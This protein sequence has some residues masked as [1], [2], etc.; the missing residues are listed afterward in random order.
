[1]KNARRIHLIAAVLAACITAATAT[2][3]V[4]ATGP[5]TGPVTSPQQQALTPEPPS[6]E[7][8]LVKLPPG[9]I[10]I[11]LLGIDKRPDKAFN[12]TDVI[13]IASINTEIPAVS[14]LSIP[15]D[16][17]VHI[18]GV[19]FYKVNT[20]FAS[21]GPDLFKQTIRYNFGIDISNYAMVNFTG[22]VHAVDALGGIDVIAT[23][24][25]KH[26]FPRDPYYMGDQYIVREAHKDNF[27]GEIW[28]VGSKVPRTVINIP[29]PGVYSLQGLE[30]L[31]F[32]RARY[33]V[34]GGDVDRGRR[35]QRVVRA[36]LQ[37]ARQVGS[38]GRL[39]QLYGKLKD[40]VQTDMTVET[41]LRFATMI[42]RLGDTLIRSR[43]LV[44]YDANG[45]ALPDA[46]DPTLNRTQ[47]IEQALNVALNQRT[48]DGIPIT[49]LN[50]TNDA[51]FV[52]AATDRLKE[53]GFVVTD[54][55]P[56]N[57]PYA[58]SAVLD[59]TTTS[60]GSALPLLERTFD[61]DPANVKSV[62]QKD[63][64]RYTVIVGADFNTCYYAK[65]LDASGSTSITA[66]AAPSS[67]KIELPS[68]IVIT[69]SQQIEQ[70]LTVPSVSI[71]AAELLSTSSSS[72]LAP[73]FSVETFTP[74]LTVQKGDIVNVR[75]GPGIEH[76]QIGRLVG[77][78]S[79][80][81]LG[82]SLDG[83]WLNITLPKTSR[84]GWVKADIV[85]VVNAPPMTPTPTPTANGDEIAAQPTMV[86]ITKQTSTPQAAQ[87]LGRSTVRAIVPAGDFVNLRTGPGV[88]YR[89]IGMLNQKQSAS[90][91]GRSSDKRWWQVRTARGTLAWL[92][93]AYVRVTGDAS[94]IPVTQ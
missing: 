55:Q 37:K 62:P 94:N 86:V 92:A 58:K 65:T 85:D 7:A 91:V 2:S 56:A 80:P 64:S 50:G 19:G 88:N 63:G 29:K 41:I 23:C 67:T 22:V 59:H 3:T 18:P 1:M 75:S 15:R 57:K 54:V 26:A 69:T 16:T 60:K 44:G 71:E 10:N 46:P 78:Q 72:R 32:V 8:P 25:L 79:A 51:G 11:A 61:I 38:L 53:V 33:G 20:A 43:Y 90:I 48:N 30:A 73:M 39:T 89:V 27:T 17:R 77:G 28:P 81:I 84:L 36:L 83:E 68:T 14:F 5:V 21:G 6:R 66:N 12:N 9:T 47:F 87:P 13:I 93:T 74:T 82:R 35:E 70:P 4:R 42:D 40:D 24:P 34:P 45:A 76:R 31:A 49:V 52:A